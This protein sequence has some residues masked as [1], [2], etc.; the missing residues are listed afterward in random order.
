VP[1][2]T[3]EP[4]DRE[5][6]ETLLVRLPSDLREQV[7]ERAQAEERTQAQVVR[8]ALRYYMDAVPA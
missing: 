3:A 2:A 5:T 1:A 6:L 4:S 8:R 7:R